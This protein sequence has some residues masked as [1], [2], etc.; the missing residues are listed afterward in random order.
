MQSD[1][2]PTSPS[3]ERQAALATL[4]DRASRLAAGEPGA[5]TAYMRQL[6]EL[7]EALIREE[8]AAL[9]AVVADAPLELLA[10]AGHR[11]L[12]RY[13]RGLAAG[14]SDRYVEAQA[15]LAALLAEP[16]LDD[17]VRGR[18]LNSAAIFAQSQADYQYARDCF[19][20]S[21]ALWGRLG[22][23]LRQGLARNNLGAL[24]YDLQ[25]YDAAEACFREAVELFTAAGSPYHLAQAYNELGLLARD[26]G[27]WDEARGWLAQAGE[28]AAQERAADLLGR[29]WNNAGE[30]E[31]LCGEF[32][33]ARSLFERALAQMATRV[34]EVDVWVNLGLID[35][36][37]GDDER[38]LEDYG[39]ALALAEQ[40]GRQ[41]I[42]PLLHYRRGHALRRLGRADEAAASYAAAAAAIEATRAP[43]RDEGLLIGL[44]G[45]WQL[46]YEA[47]IDLCLERG[48]A[49]A[50]LGYA[51]RARAR[52]FA[53]L[54]AR[55]HLELPAPPPEPLSAAEI[56]A[57][58]P[59]G[60]LLLA[61]FSAGMRG[62]ESALL[63]AIPTSA[64][65]LRACL[66]A[67]AFLARFVVSRDGLRAE[68]C[69]LDP[70]LLQAGSPYLADGRRF[71][72][73]AILRRCY[74]ALI[75]PLGADLAGADQ[76]FVAPHG[77][78][79][80]LP[81]AA[82][83]SPEGRPLIELAPRLSYVPSA[84]VLLR[85]AQ[86]PATPAS[87]PCLAIGYDGGAGRALRHTE[88]EAAAV[89]ALCSGES[90]RG[91][92]GLRDRLA[93]AAGAY[94]RLHLACHGEFD[95]A[96]PLASWLEIGP[97][98]RLS[99]AEV[100]AGPRLRAEL[101]ALSACRSGVSRVLR[102]DEPLGLVRAFL[103]AGAHA[104]LVTLWEV[105][106]EPARLL[107]EHFYAALTHENAHPAAALRAA[108]QA[109][110]AEPAYAD[111]AHW[112][113]YVLV[114][115]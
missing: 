9:A 47:A 87:R 78:L 84:T 15:I 17:A 56:Q 101:V 93:E 102:G 39:A 1:P 60:A 46:V 108:Q 26:R 18:A 22:N 2:S 68:R 5:E 40:I 71:L 58:L 79:H 20:A 41:D 106:D 80:Q 12:L 97:G 96:D 82:L 25:E 23:P 66:Q 69:P 111:P 115:G 7:C 59:A 28:L 48:D 109:L 30:V 114:E 63:E 94:R 49:A 27:R 50:A 65:G 21:Y 74:E 61:F 6:S 86:A 110:R 10:E 4:A 103:G 70:N 113:A 112:A 45:R 67:P 31:L 42:L 64:A 105:E 14:L 72:R 89:A 99:A 34:Y 53:D 38:A 54:L 73:P 33:A 52:A 24:H 32:A 98:E 91:A 81:F 55:R 90:W 3:P 43:L 36:A 107:M 95:L 8:P 77:P 44:M 11:Q 51:E 76:I 92:S 57:G 19:A 100:L 37:G 75:G 85:A 104:V 29:I 88:A 13:Y 62:P 83:I 35:Q 16:E